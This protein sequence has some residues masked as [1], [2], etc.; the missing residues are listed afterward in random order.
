M[1][2]LRAHY[3]APEPIE[4]RGIGSRPRA[5]GLSKDGTVPAADGL[6][7]SPTRGLSR[8]NLSRSVAAIRISD[9]G[10]NL[11]DQRTDLVQGHL[12]ERCT[13]PKFV[14]IDNVIDQPLI[15]AGHRETAMR[16]ADRTSGSGDVLAGILGAFWP[17]V[18]IPPSRRFRRC[19]STVR[20]G[21]CLVPGT[22]V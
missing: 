9:L 1:S 22:E 10:P 21:G 19:I 14:E 11:S 16:D 15:V 3:R 20:P 8:H 17:V 12:V 6:A 5:G 13:Y 2:A 4:R 18:P 7:R